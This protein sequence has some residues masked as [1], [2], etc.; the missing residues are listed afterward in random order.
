MPANDPKRCGVI[1]VLSAILMIVMFAMAALAIDVGYMYVVRTQLQAAADAGALAAG[2][3]LHLTNDEIV[4]V[5]KNYVTKHQAGGRAIRDSEAE[6]EL[7]VWDAAS[8][9]F[10]AIGGA[11]VGNAVRVTAKRSDENLFF[12]R[13]MGQKMFTTE[14]S[15]IAMANPKD[16]VF[17]VDAS[18][19]M[20]DDTE[21]AWATST[22]N[23]EFASAGFGSIGSQLMTQVYQDFG[24]GSFPG[25][26]EYLGAPL[27]V[28]P[29]HMAFGDMTSDVGPLA[30][31]SMPSQYKIVPGDDEFARRE[32]AYR[33]IIDHQLSRLMP[34]AK[35]APTSANYV[36]WEKYIDYVL[37]GSHVVAP[38]PPP[39]PSPPSSPS[40]GPGPSPGPSPPSGP[41]PPPPP[42]P[43]LG[44]LRG[45]TPIWANEPA[46]ALALLGNQ[47]LGGGFAW[48]ALTAQVYGPAASGPGLPRVG[49]LYGGYSGYVPP[50]QDGDRIYQFNNPNKAT[51]PGADSGVPHQL[52]NYFG[53]VT[54]VQ[55]L[56]DHGRDLRPDDAN[57]VELS[58]DSAMAPMRNETVAGRSFRF[59]PREQPM[60]AARRA[61]ITAIDVVAQRNELVPS[62]PHRDR[63]SIVTFD[64]VAGS[65]VRQNLTPN[66]DTAM[67]SVTELQSVGDKSTTTATETGL[68]LAQQILKKQSEG[69]QAREDSTKVV[70]LLTDGVP[71]AYHSSN[72]AI[73]SFAAANPGGEFVGGGYYW[74]DAALMQTMQLH[75]KKVDVYPVGVGLG[76]DYD[77]MDRIARA[78]GTGTQSPRGSGNPAE[79][80]QIMIEI[81]EKIIK[82]PVA[83]LVL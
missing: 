81:F 44:W 25:N 66:Y 67:Q 12:A 54:Y 6:V 2:N 21:P 58:V 72:A 30:A 39:P 22:I 82:R 36:Y 49:G 17:V 24:Y 14:A 1:I 79:Y 27:G 78:G 73:D 42:S 40:P 52:R 35:P 20:N 60:H 5:G 32:K 70:V 69:G 7:G 8:Q 29:G 59:P 62:A 45:N 26:V 13:V 10:S 51:F 34:A 61:I 47:R 28:T 50:N 75:A 57:L 74:I 37:D 33:W 83:K 55:F 53:Y 4:R 31:A 43:P 16:I 71:N 38:S 76:T 64:T 41:S 56:M 65:V 19:S 80:E 23:G 77:F 9:S 18:G 11:A 15:A 46:A 63:V 3:S 68:A 48:Y